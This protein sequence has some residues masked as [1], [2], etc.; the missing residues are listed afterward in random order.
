[1][2][3]RGRARARARQRHRTLSLKSASAISKRDENIV[4]EKQGRPYVVKGE[5]CLK[6]ERGEEDDRNVT[7][8]KRRREREEERDRDGTRQERGSERT[9]FAVLAPAINNALAYKSASY[10]CGVNR[11]RVCVISHLRSSRVS[12]DVTVSL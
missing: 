5:R 8:R 7:E 12:C 1:M 2:A 11:A 9:P 3:K 10:T 4:R 6:W